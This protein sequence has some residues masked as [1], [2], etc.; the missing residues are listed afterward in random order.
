MYKLVVLAALVAVASAGLLPAATLPIA[1]PF[2]YAHHA[3]LAYA[4]PIA[5]PIATAYAAPAVIPAPVTYHT[6]YKVETEVEPVEQ[7]GYSIK[8]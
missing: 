6:G 2:A 7:H 1:T 4:A 3:P 8:Y 5:A